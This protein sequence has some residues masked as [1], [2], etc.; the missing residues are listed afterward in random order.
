MPPAV[1][2]VEVP[3][4]YGQ[5]ER[6]RAA[7]EGIA[8]IIGDQPQSWGVSVSEAADQSGWLVK[9]TSPDKAWALVFDGPDQQT[10][11]AIVEQFRFNLRPYLPKA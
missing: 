1:V 3:D 11:T 8:R 4:V 7:A 10:E 6:A 2:R 9:V 5:R